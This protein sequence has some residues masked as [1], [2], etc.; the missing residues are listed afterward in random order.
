VSLSARLFSTLV[1]LACIT[2]TA[3]SDGGTPTPPVQAAVAPGNAAAY[4]I[5]GNVSGAPGASL[6]F[7]GAATVS[8][9]TDS[10]GNYIAP[11]APSGNY[12]VTPSRTGYVFNPVSRAETL[13]A[14]MT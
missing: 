13:S 11:A 7:M 6:R 14:A 4:T 5:S 8:T 3:C 12:T 1:I 2:L 10:S 9:V